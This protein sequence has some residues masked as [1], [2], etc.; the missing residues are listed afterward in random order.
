MVDKTVLNMLQKKY[1][2]GTRICCDISQETGSVK[3]GCQGTVLGIDNNTGQIMRFWDNGSFRS[4]TPGK[5]GFHIV[6]PKNEQSA[7]NR[8]VNIESLSAVKKLI[9]KLT[10]IA[11]EMVSHLGTDIQDYDIDEMIENE[12]I[13]SHVVGAVAEIYVHEDR[14]VINMNC[15]DEEEIIPFEAENGSYLSAVGEPINH[16]MNIPITVSVRWHRC[17]VYPEIPSRSIGKDRLFRGNESPAA[18]GRMISLPM[19]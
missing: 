3:A 18:A 2:A 12:D 7:E 19:K 11:D 8:A 16:I 13:R 9:D 1:P 4:L 6:Q 17:W 14:A 10:N 5:D 15:C